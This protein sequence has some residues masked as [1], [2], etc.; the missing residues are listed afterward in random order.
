MQ[1]RLNPSIFDRLKQGSE[2]RIA[3]IE[4]A[5]LADA[6]TRELEEELEKDNLLIF[7]NP[8][9]TF[10]TKLKEDL[11][12]IIKPVRGKVAVPA[13][14]V[15]L[16]VAVA[17]G[18]EKGEQSNFAQGLPQELIR[19]CRSY[20]TSETVG[21]EGDRKGFALATQYYFD[22]KDD[23]KALYLYSAG[24]LFTASF[25]EAYIGFSLIN[26]P[27]DL[28]AKQSNIANDIVDGLNK[29][30]GAEGEIFD[31]P[32]ELDEA[33]D[34]LFIPLGNLRRDL[35]DNICP[36]GEPIDIGE[37]DHSGES[38]LKNLFDCAVEGDVDCQNELITKVEA[39]PI[40]LKGVLSEDIEHEY[41]PGAF[42]PLDNVF[43]ASTDM[44][45]RINGG[46]PNAVE[47]AVSKVIEVLECSTHSPCS[48]EID[49]KE[50]SLESGDIE[51][52]IGQ[53][54]LNFVKS[55]AFVYPPQEGVDLVAPHIDRLRSVQ[56]WVEQR[57]SSTNS[58]YAIINGELKEVIF[59][60]EEQ[61]DIRE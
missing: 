24:A 61:L 4:Y 44:L 34:A 38:V 25:E 17:C 59:Y 5:R 12:K 51:K 35:E 39:S 45:F 19:V 10:L 48:V 42:A 20:A 8:E 56:Q 54:A 27:G 11:S 21:G 37:E 43:N 53:N 60:L 13:T 47:D 58:E 50:L 22:H 1:E 57:V 46:D 9:S 31:D 36:D 23:A 26:D 16:A 40:I 7:D 6:E 2:A 32:D 14:M 33:L 15:V 55:I 30:I 49:G 41:V 28:P 29:F 18:S 3:Q 52:P